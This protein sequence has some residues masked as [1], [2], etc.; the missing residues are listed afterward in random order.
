ME[1]EARK[2]DPSCTLLLC[3]LDRKPPYVL[4]RP[5]RDDVPAS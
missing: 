4:L 3:S 5:A 2:T 1:L